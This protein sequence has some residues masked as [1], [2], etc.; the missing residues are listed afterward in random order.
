MSKKKDIRDQIALTILK[1]AMGRYIHKDD[2]KVVTLFEFQTSNTFNECCKLMNENNISRRSIYSTIDM[3]MP[4]SFREKTESVK[5][6][7]DFCYEF[8]PKN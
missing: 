8:L 6:L 3:M 5:L 1:V 2:K 4:P 7:H